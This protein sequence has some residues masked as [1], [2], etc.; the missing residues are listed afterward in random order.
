MFCIFRT[1]NHDDPFL[2][3]INGLEESIKFDKVKQLEADDIFTSLDAVVKRSL[4]NVYPD[5]CV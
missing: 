1:K 5:V 2:N 3:F 4:N